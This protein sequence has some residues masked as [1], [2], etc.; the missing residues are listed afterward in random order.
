MRAI[1]RA[2][3]NATFWSGRARR[4]P[5]R[6]PTCAGSGGASPSRKWIESAPARYNLRSSL[7]PARSF[8]FDYVFKGRMSETAIRPAR[9]PSMTT[10]TS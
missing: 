10:G 4:P 3:A 7:P 1:P 6:F 2:G 9:A 5:S 8:D